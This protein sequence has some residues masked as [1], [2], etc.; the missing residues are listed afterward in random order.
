MKFYL[1]S[2]PKFQSSFSID[3]FDSVTDI[4]DVE[5]FQFRPMHQKIQDR[6]KFVEKHYKKIKKIC[7]K[8]KIKIIINND[9][10]IA[11]KFEFD[12][13]HLGKKDKSCLEAK[14]EF[15]KKFI[16][17]I[18]CENSLR[19]YYGAVKQ[20]ADYVAFGSVF[21]STT[22]KKKGVYP[23]NLIISKKKITLPFTLIGGI[24]HRNILNLKK[25][26]PNNIAV[27]SSIWNYK[28]G[29]KNS[30]VLFKK[31]LKE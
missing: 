16:V 8:K 3:N 22:K 23:D 19:K 21:N 9:F 18:S 30:A 10:E 1:I 25:L 7:E 31:I 17:G 12:G 11:K 24:N 27:I 5:Y 4:I 20:K 29:P 13:I 6:S 2:P 14:K 15:G 28:S 26:K